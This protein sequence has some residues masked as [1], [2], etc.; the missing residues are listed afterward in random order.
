VRERERI[1]RC[2]FGGEREMGN[3]TNIVLY[4]G[5]RQR[6]KKIENG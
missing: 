5:E 2:W 6:V 3:G 4:K 1:C